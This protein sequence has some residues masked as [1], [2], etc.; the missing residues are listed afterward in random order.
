MHG[1]NKRDRERIK[2]RRYQKAKGKCEYCSDP[3]N[4][5]AST[6]DHY[7][8]RDK[9][10]SN[11][12]TNFRLACAPCNQAKSNLTPEEWELKLKTILAGKQKTLDDAAWQLKLKRMYPCTKG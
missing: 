8:A 3:L 5:L 7:I 9:G 11:R 12:T 1:L 2:R 6:L 10:G 4:Y